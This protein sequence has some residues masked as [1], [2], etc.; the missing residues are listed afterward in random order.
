MKRVFADFKSRPD[1]SPPWENHFGMLQHARDVAAVSNHI[2]Y[3][4]LA[5]HTLFRTNFSYF[6]Q[7]LEIEIRILTNLVSLHNRQVV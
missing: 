1:V 6:A 4:V 3:C 5:T 2:D 7:S